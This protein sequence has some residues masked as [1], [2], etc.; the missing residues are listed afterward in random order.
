MEMKIEETCCLRQT[1]LPITILL[2]ILQFALCSA[3]FGQT[4]RENV[5]LIVSGATVVTM[6]PKRA[7]YEDGSVAVKGDSIGAVRPRGE[8]E[9]KYKG[10]QT[11]D[12]NA[13]LSLPGVF[14]DLPHLPMPS[15]RGL[16]Y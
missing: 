2:L 5:D 14:I 8:I 3:A 16:S 4:N 11:I 10:L 12:G 7:I 9:S 15:R 6:D 13:W 1:E